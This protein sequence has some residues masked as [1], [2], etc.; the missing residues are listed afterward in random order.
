[1]VIKTWKTL[2]LYGVIHWY[3]S[4]K[5]NPVRIIGSG[6][7]TCDTGTSSITFSHSTP[8]TFDCDFPNEICI[9]R[10]KIL[11]IIDWVILVCGLAWHDNS[12]RFKTSSKILLLIFLIVPLSWCFNAFLKWI[13]SIR[14]VYKHIIFSG[15]YCASLAHSHS[16]IH[17]LNTSLTRK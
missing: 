15:S 8:T 12:V 10:M 3:T 13:W 14:L 11:N 7:F 2:G 17:I 9:H 6:L 4:Q 1:M 16:H 5:I